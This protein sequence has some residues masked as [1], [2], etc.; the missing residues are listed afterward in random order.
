MEWKE[1]HIAK[2]QE[3]DGGASEEKVSFGKKLRSTLK[4]GDLQ[5]GA[6][7]LGIKI[8]GLFPGADK[9]KKSQAFSVSNPMVPSGG[10]STNTTPTKQAKVMSPQQTQ[11]KML[12]GNLHIGNGIMGAYT[13][14]YFV[15]RT[16]DHSLKFYKPDRLTGEVLGS[17]DLKQTSKVDFEEKNGKKDTQKFILVVAGQ[18]VKMRAESAEEANKWVNGLNEWVTYFKETV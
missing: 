8:G 9:E 10:G 14:K 17:F 2:K 18:I 13:E 3:S 11:P 6:A 5:G 16:T 7:S 4:A 15:I 1:Y 12:S